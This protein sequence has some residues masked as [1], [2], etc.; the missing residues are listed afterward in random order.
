MIAWK[1]D[2]KEAHI[3]V[4]VKTNGLYLSGNENFYWVTGL[5]FQFQ[6]E[7]IVQREKEWKLKLTCPAT[8]KP[9]ARSDEVNQTCKQTWKAAIGV[10]PSLAALDAAKVTQ[11]VAAITL[12]NNRK[13][14]IPA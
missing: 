13:P 14:E 6:F 3:S 1:N 7:R 11:I 12:A 10:E 8:A 9:S 4:Q 5:E 2:K